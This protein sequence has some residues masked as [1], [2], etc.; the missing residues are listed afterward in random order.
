[1]FGAFV[2]IYT[3]CAV[4]FSHPKHHLRACLCTHFTCLRSSLRSLC[5]HDVC[6]SVPLYTLCI[7]FVFASF[8]SLTHRYFSSFYTLFLVVVLSCANRL[9]M[10]A[11]LGLQPIGMVLMS[12]FSNWM[13]SLLWIAMLSHAF[14]T[15]LYLS[16]G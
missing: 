13:R 15:L 3:L 11:L 12:A 9:F 8:H 14:V 16:I 2:H 5:V 6:A 4:L 10:H 1:M 7:T